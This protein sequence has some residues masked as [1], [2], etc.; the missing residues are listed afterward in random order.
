MSSPSSVILPVTRAPSMVSFMRLRQRRK[1]DLP[2][3]D[4]PI[5]AVTWFCADV[6]IDVEQ[7]LLLAVEDAD[8]VAAHLDHF[9]GR[10]AHV[11]SSPLFRGHVS[12]MMFIGAY[13]MLP[14]PL[15]AAAQHDRGDV[16]DHQEDEQ[17][18]IAPDMR[19]TKARSA[20]LA[21]M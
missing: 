16:H 12:V 1:V 21:H 18:M 9:V 10:R 3:P 14:A 17:M 4:G 5:S 20:S 6:E 15:E 13:S 19:S 11:A 7:R 8:L 2:Q